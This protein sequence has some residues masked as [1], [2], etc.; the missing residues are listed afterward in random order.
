MTQRPCATAAEQA[1]AQ[2]LDQLPTAESV[3]GS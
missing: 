2:L 3:A 1:E